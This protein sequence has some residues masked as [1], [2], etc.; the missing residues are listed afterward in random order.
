MT[1]TTEKNSSPIIA[2]ASAPGRGENWE[3]HGRILTVS[4]A[5]TEPIVAC[6]DILVPQSLTGQTATCAIAL[7]VIYPAGDASGY[8]IE[9]TRL[10]HSLT[11]NLAP[12]GAGSL[13]T[14]LWWG[15]TLP[16]LLLTVIGGILLVRAAGSFSSRAVPVRVLTV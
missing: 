6:V 10:Q 9:R 15:T 3:G 13:Y 11:L 1:F 5:P 4:V 12:P 2:N 14:A 7:D 16:G 8:H